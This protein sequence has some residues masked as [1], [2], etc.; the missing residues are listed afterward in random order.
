MENNNNDNDTIYMMETLWLSGWCVGVVTR[1]STVRALA[2]VVF[3]G[4]KHLT[5]TVP[6]STQVYKW[7]PENCFGDNLGGNLRWTSIP[8]RG[9]RNT[10]SRFILQKPEISAGLMGL[11]SQLRLGP[12]LPSPFLL[13]VE[14]DKL[15][16]VAGRPK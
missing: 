13:T 7:E 4:K 1:R 3:L 6:L 15:T 12:T 10:R 2:H 9:S 14:V 8:S 5:I 11:L 16:R